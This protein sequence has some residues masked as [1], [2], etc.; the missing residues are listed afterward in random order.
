MLE[1]NCNNNMKIQKSG[2]LVGVFLTIGVL[3]IVTLM[4]KGD[5]LS[6]N[7][8]NSLVYNTT[9]GIIT[10]KNASNNLATLDLKTKPTFNPK[11]QMN[12]YTAQI[13]LDSKFAEITINATNY[14][15][16]NFIQSVSFRNM[17]DNSTFTRPVT[18]KVRS[19]PILTRNT[20]KWN[21]T[22]LG[23]LSSQCGYVVNG[24]EQ[25]AAETWTVLNNS[26]FSGSTTVGL[27][28]EI[29]SGDFFDYVPT[30]FGVNVTQWSIVVGD[31]NNMV[32]FGADDNALTILNNSV[33]NKVMNGTLINADQWNTTTKKLGASAITLKSGTIA[34]S[35]I[36]SINQSMVLKNFTIN[37]WAWKEK[38]S[39]NGYLVGQQTGGLAV[40][41]G[42]D[43]SINEQVR[44]VANCAGAINSSI[45]AWE[46]I[47]ATVNGLNYTV[48]RNGL[49][50][51]T[52]Q[53][54]SVY[55]GSG[56]L[57]FGRQ[58][59]LNIASDFNGTID[60]IMILNRSL[61]QADITTLW[62]NGQG[63]NPFTSITYMCNF[64]GHV[65]DA[66]SNPLNLTNITIFNQAN[67]GESYYTYTNTSGDWNYSIS[68]STTGG[69]NYTV[70]ARL[71][72]TIA[73]GY[74]PYISG[75][76]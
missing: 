11:Y 51:A 36:A 48:Y 67:L 29:K 43:N 32:Y 46:M 26:V 53:F 38:N 27:F 58:D 60:E 10:V 6:N 14:S 31:A 72:N 33:N 17:I 19:D 20:T 52:C 49:P 63:F 18:Y 61:S 65:Q 37:L 15:Y 7:T 24:T 55:A 34:T 47:T 2:V 12:V 74:K 75:T 16:Q 42:S 1:W 28:T 22:I 41:Y 59:D 35:R 66:S 25:Y 73:G 71:N 4:V 5:I 64:T 45:Q 23:N 21:C 54:A 50:A 68:N 56:W 40:Y 70:L 57:E 44:G 9:T 30:M 76:C 69:K 8:S 13:G 3:I 62:N 39:T